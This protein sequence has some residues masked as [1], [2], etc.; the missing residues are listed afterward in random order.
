MNIEKP[1]A[2]SV[3]MSTENKTSHTTQS[4]EESLEK[5][6]LRLMK[7]NEACAEAAIRAG[8]R[9][10]FGY[11][12]T[13][14]N[15]LA[16][17]MSKRM[18]QVEGVFVQ[19]ESEIS[20]IN[21]VYGASAAGF[22]ALTSSSSPGVALKAE[23][24]SYLAG[25]DLPSVIINISRGGPGLGTIQ[26]SQGDYFMATKAPGH[27]DFKCLVYAP[28]SVQEMADMVTEAFNKSDQ[29]RMPAIILADGMLGQM[30]EPVSLPAMPNDQKLQN[31]RDKP[32]AL[33]GTLTASKDDN[34][35]FRSPREINSLHLVPEEL[36]AANLDRF[37]RYEHIIEH[38]QRAHHYLTDDAEIIV[39]AYGSTGRTVQTSIDIARAAGIKAGL[40]RP[41][42]VW[43]FP[44]AAI[45]DL[46]LHGNLRAILSIEMSMGQMVE[47][48]LLATCGKVPVA[49]YNRTGGFVPDPVIVAEKIKELYD[50]N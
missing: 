2:A 37:A 49:T 25:A 15:E 20:A 14:Q 32:W 44:N 50:N 4:L 29:Y 16:A 12:I 40:L 7:G 6:P 3:K 5:E 46:I 24:I 13:P 47:D 30:M 11:P 42:L 9:A 33:T 19:A 43:P 8:C 39:V 26:P 23:G 41:Q 22:R 17:Y 48:V 28:A 34:H 38:E 10:Y 31:N 27:G 35:S 21:M 18:P 1:K 36:E 45:E